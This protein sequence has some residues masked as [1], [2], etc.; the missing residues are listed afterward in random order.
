MLVVTWPSG[1]QRVKLAMGG[2]QDSRLIQSVDLENDGKSIYVALLSAPGI[3]HKEDLAPSYLEKDVESSWKRPF[4]AKWI[5]Q[6][7]EA[8]VQ[9]RFTFRESK[10]P[11]IWRGAAGSCRGRWGRTRSSSPATP[12]APPARSSGW[13][14]SS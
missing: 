5:T 9:T 8:G 12:W 4:P 2:S 13:H 3:W 6:L 10:L 11:R 1:Q 14:S 7:D